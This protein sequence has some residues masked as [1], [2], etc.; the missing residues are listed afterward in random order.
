MVEGYKN[1]NFDGTLQRYIIQFTRELSLLITCNSFQDGMILC[2]LIHKYNSTLI[3]YE[4]LNPVCF[5]SLLICEVL[6]I[7]L[8]NR[9]TGPIT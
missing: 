9:K 7:L 6:F 1:V 5:Y 2:A 3:D 8:I 4:I